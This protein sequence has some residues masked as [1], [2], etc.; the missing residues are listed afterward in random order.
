MADK[1]ISALTAAST[2]VAGTEVLPIVQSGSTV[3]VSIDNLTKGR[4]VNASTFDTDVAAAGVTLSGTTLAADGTN[5]NIDISIVPK[6]TGTVR[7]FNGVRFASQAGDTNGR[8]VTKLTT[9]VTTSAVEITP[10]NNTWGNLF[11]VTGL[12]SGGAY[13]TDL[14]FTAATA[15]PTVLSAKTI[16][17][18]PAARTYSMSGSD[19]LRVA[20][21]SGTY[22]IHAAVFSGLN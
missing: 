17:G 14:V 16:S 21:A 1:K 19:G 2:P 4:T 3:K 6:G 9:G 8:L 7:A 13:F 12:E 11:I 22:D 18:S 5:T 20:M 15:G 10:V